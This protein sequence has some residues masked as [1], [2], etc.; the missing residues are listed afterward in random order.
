MNYYC[1]YL[2]AIIFSILT[3]NS[4]TQEVKKSSEIE[5]VQG[6][7]YYIHTVQKGE[8]L[9]SIAK[10]YEVSMDAIAYENPDVFQG[11]KPEQKLKIPILA[12]PFEKKEHEV[13]KGE[14]LYGIAKK[15][16]T[17]IEEIV[18]LNPDVIKGIKPGQLLMIPVRT[19]AS[20]DYQQPKNV[21]EQKNIPSANVTKH[22]V[23]KGET[24]Y[25]ICKLYNIEQEKLYE[26]NPSLKQVNL[27]VGQELLI[28][29]TPK[30]NELNT[31]TT[32]ETENIDT[33]IK[34]NSTTI[35]AIEAIDCQKAIQTKTIKVAILLPLQNDFA[36]LEEEESSTDPNIKLS[37]KSYL[38]FYEGFLLAIDSIRKSG[39][40][41]ELWQYEI[42]RDSSKVI[43]LLNDKNLQN[44]DLIIGPF[45]E[46]IFEMVASWAESKQIPVINPVM[47]SNKALYNC[48]NVIQLNTTLNS[49]IEQF[50]R[51]MASF[52]SLNMIIVHTN[53][54]EDIQILTIYKKHYIESYTDN[55]KSKLPSLKEINYHQS[56]QEGLEKLLHRNK[57]NIVF[58]PSQSQVFVINLMTKLNELTKSYRIILCYMPTWKKFENNIELEHLFNLNTHAFQPFYIDYNRPEVNNFVRFYRFYFK[59]DPSRLSFLGFD[60]GIYFL[61]MIKNYG[62]SFYSCI[63]HCDA[64]TLSSNFYFEKVGKNG[65]YENKGLFILRYDNVENNLLLSNIVHDKFIQPLFMPSIEVRKLP[66]Y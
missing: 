3:I 28:Y 29:A 34:Q 46:N 7:K 51:Y 59:T 48:S 66:K 33:N 60:A 43:Q 50:A 12:T 9:Y 10:A 5:V 56:G 57:I 18:Q 62:K 38:E 20:A 14:T 4:Y 32:K 15:Y 41:I 58:I 11:I 47:P 22:I 36:I 8:T 61:S 40:N 24:I 27:Q 49:Q 53:S 45:H 44:A 25:G 1:I 13:Q 21:V 35:K 42:K 52:D 17:T 64:K 26:W 19:V 39:T 16:N 65:G 30:S 55:F 63:N 54:N 23:K 37:P 6:K 2:F 31:K